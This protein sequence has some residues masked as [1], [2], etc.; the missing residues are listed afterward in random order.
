MPKPE[1]YIDEEEEELEEDVFLV[2]FTALSLILLAFMIML[3]AFAKL[4]KGK[5]DKAEK[6][7]RG[8][9]GALF[10]TGFKK[11]ETMMSQSNRRHRDKKSDRQQIMKKADGFKNLKEK[12]NVDVTTNPEGRIVLRFRGDI[13]FSPGGVHLNPTSYNTLDQAADVIDKV[14]FPIRIEGHTDPVPLGGGKTNWYLSAARASATLRYLR[15]A[16][17]L[18]ADK[19]SAAGYGPSR[20]PRRKKTSPRRVEIVFMPKRGEVK[21]TIQQ[22]R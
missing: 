20:P 3:N 14:G 2:M 15:E 13:L 17:E 10:G 19:I 5:A 18:D 9:F 21:D 8:S 1:E 6:S 11:A 7:L 22:M 12:K 16:T 4:D